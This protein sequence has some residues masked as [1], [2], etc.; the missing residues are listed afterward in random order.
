M[1]MRETAELLYTAMRKNERVLRRGTSLD[2][3]AGSRIRTM[4]LERFIA[5][6]DTLAGYKIGLGAPELQLA[7]GI[8]E[9]GRGFLFSSQLV[10]DGGC[11]E[12]GGLSLLVEAE[13]AVTMGSELAGDS[14]G[15]DDILAA[16]AYSSAAIEVVGSRWNPGPD[17]SIG[18]WIADNGMAVR[19]VLGAHKMPVVRDA[20]Q[21]ALQIGSSRSVITVVPPVV[22]NLR[23]LVSD[24]AREGMSLQ[25]G[26][27][28][29][30]GSLG[31]ARPAATGDRIEVEIDGYGSV[32]VDLASSTR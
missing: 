24:L 6:G 30:T 8:D 9:P 10:P 19:A 17:G 1:S 21:V 4:V 3:I 16:I 13:V 12:S 14:L 25:A 32:R 28:V 31:E 2:A 26:M 11:V 22:Q 5:A 27:V 29:L 7:Y 20:T 23:W 18:A 15:D